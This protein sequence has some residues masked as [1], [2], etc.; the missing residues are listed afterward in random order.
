[1]MPTPWTPGPRDLGLTF[2]CPVCR[3]YRHNLTAERL[4]RYESQ[5]HCGSTHCPGNR[6]DSIHSGRR[7]YVT[8]SA[9]PPQKLEEPWH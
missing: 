1:M 4:E 8:V 6:K 5:G 7:V 3:V 9:E 2:R